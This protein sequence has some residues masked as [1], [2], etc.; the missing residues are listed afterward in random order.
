MASISRTIKGSALDFE[1]TG[2]GQRLDDLDAYSRLD[3]TS[4]GKTDLEV[5]QMMKTDLGSKPNELSQALDL[6][7]RGKRL[8]Q[9]RNEQAA[10]G[11]STA[12]TDFEI[13]KVNK[14]MADLLEKEAGKAGNT[15]FQK[16]AQEIQAQ[17]G[18]DLESTQRIKDGWDEAV[19]TFEDEMNILTAQSKISK[20]ADD[21]VDDVIKGDSGLYVINGFTKSDGKYR[22]DAAQIPHKLDPEIE[23][24]VFTAVQDLAKNNTGMDYK[25]K[26][27]NF[28]TKSKGNSMK[29]AEAIS[30]YVAAKMDDMSLTQ[31]ARLQKLAD[32]CAS[33]HFRDMSARDLDINAAVQ[34]KLI[35][36][37]LKEVENPNSVFKL[38]ELP[39]EEL[40]MVVDLLGKNH[41]NIRNIL[42]KEQL[43]ALSFVGMKINDMK[44]RDWAL[45]VD[46]ESSDGIITASRKVC[47]DFAV[48]KIAELAKGAK[49]SEIPSD[50]IGTV[51]SMDPKILQDFK[52][53]GSEFDALVEVDYKGALQS[54]DGM[55][56]V[57]VEF[58]KIEAMY[59]DMPRS[60]QVK[61]EEYFASKSSA[62]VTDHKC[63]KLGSWPFSKVSSRQ[64]VTRMI[65]RCANWFNFSRMKRKKT[66]PKTEVP[67]SAGALIGKRDTG[68][69]IPEPEPEKAPTTEFDRIDANKVMESKYTEGVFEDVART[70]WIDSF[71]EYLG[72]EKKPIKK[73]SES[74]RGKNDLI[75]K[76]SSEDVALAGQPRPVDITEVD[77]K[78][79]ML[80]DSEMS[81]STGRTSGASLEF[82]DLPANSEHITVVSWDPPPPKK[83]KKVSL[84]Q[85]QDEFEM[86]NN[87]DLSGSLDV[88]K[89]NMNPR[90]LPNGYAKARAKAKTK[91]EKRIVDI[92]ALS[93]MWNLPPNAVLKYADELA[94]MDAKRGGSLVDIRA[95]YSSNLEADFFKKFIKEP[96]SLNMTPSQYIEAAGARVGV[97]EK[98]KELKISEINESIGGGLKL[99]P[100]ET[101]KALKQGNINR[102]KLQIN[103]LIPDSLV[104]D[105]HRPTVTQ[106]HK[107]QLRS[108]IDDF[109]V[110]SPD[111]DLSELQIPE[112]TPAEVKSAEAMMN[113]IEA[114]N[115]ARFR[116]NPDLEDAFKDWKAKEFK[117]L[118]E[119]VQTMEVARTNEFGGDRVL[120]EGINKTARDI[121]VEDG[122]L[123][124]TLAKHRLELE[125]E[126]IYQRNGGQE[127][128]F[129]E[130]GVT[131]FKDA[132]KNGNITRMFDKRKYD[133][134]LKPNSRVMKALEKKVKEMGIDSTKLKKWDDVDNNPN[135]REFLNSNGNT[136]N[137]EFLDNH[138]RKI[139]LAKYGSILGVAGVVIFFLVDPDQGVIS[140]AI[141]QARLNRAC[142]C[143]ELRMIAGGPGGKKALDDKRAE[144][145]V[146]ELVTWGDT[147]WNN[148]TKGM[149]VDKVVRACENQYCDGDWDPS[150]VTF[151]QLDQSV[152]GGYVGV[153]RVNPDD[154][155]RER[156]FGDMVLDWLTPLNVFILIILFLLLVFATRGRIQRG[157]ATVQSGVSRVAKGNL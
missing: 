86:E 148:I 48:E 125:G 95:N 30:A 111:I 139:Q 119:Q 99:S 19:D 142:K 92:I 11:Q 144:N 80:K 128:A 118:E 22:A 136:F 153:V 49:T 36:G 151:Q 57:D 29:Q 104:K 141:E 60:V 96:G 107:E 157:V 16:K 59:P 38:K 155:M 103:P 62:L 89:E 121:I 61:F 68:K 106:W 2:S 81:G 32:S 122:M 117:K 91:A 20:L 27:I 45:K 127:W 138:K 79:Q 42:P 37:A 1:Y 46:V 34:R 70:S 131:V 126:I 76:P 73:V 28:N 94:K 23:N 58:K 112:F 67:L 53:R 134:L 40:S 124:T 90:P 5:V 120:G 110:L 54:V 44:P 12:V 33:G 98:R 150:Q 31:I 15:E 75:E 14:E 114:H 146:P 83:I 39:Q 69:D 123:K 63:R 71:S 74:L 3:L 24:I 78:A 4:G 100:L 137:Q 50:L 10:A 113:K 72:Y 135:F 43:D 55:G 105:N 25:S 66:K 13:A 6:E 145:P 56:S 154:V 115:A 93:Y 102:T 130:N 8:S 97:M 108:E 17:R 35:L 143:E 152:G 21:F 51:R 101:R 132:P 18:R 116:Q 149:D 9:R 47:G 52:D 88:T 140:K 129:V 87:T 84:E 64:F 156:T 85:A 133:K 7:S 147:Y 77:I 41:P 26:L 65:N 82:E 109:Q